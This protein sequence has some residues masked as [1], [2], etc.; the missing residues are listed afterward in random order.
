M[1][2]KMTPYVCISDHQVV[3]RVTHLLGTLGAPGEVV[4]IVV[5]AS[6]PS[7]GRLPGR[8]GSLAT[9]A[10]HAQATGLEKP[11]AS[12][13]TL[14]ELEVRI[15]GTPVLF[16]QY[17]AGGIGSLN[18]MKLFAYLL[19]CRESWRSREPIQDA[20]W[21]SEGYPERAAQRFYK[22]LT[23]VNAVF[24]AALG[25]AGLRAVVSR[26][27][28]YRLTR[29]FDWSVDADVFSAMIDQADVVAAGNDVNT[30]I[31][32]YGAALT[33]CEG[34]YMMDMPREDIPPEDAGVSHANWWMPLREEIWSRRRYARQQLGKL[35]LLQHEYHLVINLCSSALREP[36]Q[37]PDDIRALGLLALTAFREAGR[38]MEGLRA[39][40]TLERLLPEDEGGPGRRLIEAA[41][42]LR[43][44]LQ[45]Q[46]K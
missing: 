40:D 7:T 45:G 15:N 21:P 30:A 26:Y 13:H 39:Y 1:L 44:S 24:A 9:A 11:L 35:H 3:K 2:P 36:D 8:N 25:Q 32:L 38:G 19:H 43:R 27:G 42:A 10:E 5:K 31:S 6:D 20:V 41:E 37:D 18:I 34:D 46:E 33:M 16:D 29:Q 23:G 28:Q 4:G 22:S 14:G 17:R 12:V